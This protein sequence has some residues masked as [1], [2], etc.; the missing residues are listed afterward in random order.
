MSKY[1]SLLIV[2][3][4]VSLLESL[5]EPLQSK[6]YQVTT[7]SDAAKAL[8]LVKKKYL[9]TVL[10]DVLMP[11]MNGVE[12][13]QE[14]KKISSSTVVILMTGELMEDHLRQT[15]KEGS[16]TVLYKPFNIEQLLDVFKDKHRPTILI[17]DDQWKDR[18][19]F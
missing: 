16:Y 3:D 9:A 14:I 13:L 7:V 17:A 10:T 6:G 15:I 8:E 5:R 19:V 1:K 11:G 18:E 12:L 2:D 4:N